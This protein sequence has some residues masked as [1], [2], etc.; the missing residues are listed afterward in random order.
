MNSQ[1]QTVYVNITDEQYDEINRIL[2][3]CSNHTNYVEPEN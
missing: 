3:K 1:S 2:S